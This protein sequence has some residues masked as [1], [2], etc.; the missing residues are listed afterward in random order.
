[1]KNKILSIMAVLAMV[2]GGVAVSG[3][4]AQTASDMPAEHEDIGGHKDHHMGGPSDGAF[5][6][7]F[8]DAGIFANL[9]LL[10]TTLVRSTSRINGL[11]RNSL[12]RETGKFQERNREIP[13]TNRETGSALSK[14][15]NEAC[16]FV[17]F[18]PA[19][20]TSPEEERYLSLSDRDDA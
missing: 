9:G 5:H 17:P 16:Y 1:M 20:L 18:R 2:W 12:Q 3:S 10:T 4:L 6:H 8:E 14:Q 15:G 11:R 13:T 7:R 19:F